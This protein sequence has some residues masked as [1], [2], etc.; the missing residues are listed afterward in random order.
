MTHMLLRFAVSVLG[1]LGGAVIGE[2][3][4]EEKSV[5][6]KVLLLG[7]SGPVYSVAFSPVGKMLANQN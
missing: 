7:H 5:I 1:F 2:A 3:R 4:A 6:E